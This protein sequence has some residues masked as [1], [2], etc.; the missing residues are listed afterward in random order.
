MLLQFALAAAL[1]Q[2]PN[3]DQVLDRVRD[4]VGY[5]QYSVGRGVE[6]KGSS[7]Y[8]GLDMTFS[9]L[10]EPGGR[11]VFEVV[12]R[13]GQKRGWDGKVAWDADTSGSTS[14]MYM[15]ALDLQRAFSWTVSHKWLDPEGPF[16]VSLDKEQP[17]GSN[18]T[19]NLKLKGGELTQ[20]VSIN[21]LSNL[22]EMTRFNSTVGEHKVFFKNW[23][24]TEF[25]TFAHQIETDDVGVLGS[26]TV[27]SVSEMPVFVR[28]PFTMPLWSV[29]QDTKYD[30]TKEGTVMTMRTPQ[31]HI[32]V[33]PTID[34]KDIGWFILDSGAGGMVIDKAVAERLGG[35]RFGEMLVGGV[36]GVS[37]SGY[38]QFDGFKLGPATVDGML[39]I[40]FDLAPFS[41]I[42]GVEIG[43][44]VGYDFFR[45][46][47]VVFDH[48]E[49]E[50]KVYDPR[51]SDM[52]LD[53]LAL[54]LDN[55]HATVEAEFEGG[56]RGR[57]RI[58]TG[59][60]GTVSFNRPTVIEHDML[61]GR[62]TTKSL[63]RGFN[64][65][66]ESRTGEL[67][68][69]EMAGKRWEDVQAIFSTSDEGV[70]RSGYLAGNLGHGLLRAFRIVFDYPN[71][72]IAMVKK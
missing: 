18:Y 35:E 46:T 24:K 3:V 19:L 59:A 45:R 32:L 6:L 67:K 49:A 21:A 17:S 34:R 60:N 13:A 37:K 72:R 33:R 69:F 66:V 42:F 64:G 27:E 48:A 31:G 20:R 8:V 12:G 22:P 68:Y 25:G 47:T 43:G 55:R 38:Y 52:E 58:D 70:H 26:F 23:K 29:D 36:G 16:E 1:W 4:A 65:T 41:D 56:H 7:R 11:Y 62:S 14:R 15:E 54:M 71:D 39:F 9:F 44:I 40:E 5:S 2:Q 57:F 61:S 53:W 10:F 28:S 51:D 63:Q 50:V 30:E